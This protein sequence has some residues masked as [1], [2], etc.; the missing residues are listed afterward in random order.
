MPDD[1]DR[2]QERDQQFQ[3]DS[4]IDRRYRAA[5]NVLPATGYCLFCTAPLPGA[6]R[7]CNADCRDDWDHEMTLKRRQG[8]K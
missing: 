7:F 6:M 8:V 5:Q 4:E 1:I 2:A 3:A